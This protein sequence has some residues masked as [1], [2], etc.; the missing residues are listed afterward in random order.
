MAQQFDV[1]VVGAGIVGTSV[2]YRL[3][4]RG[5]RVALV[6]ANT[7]ASGVSSRSFAWF[8]SEQ[9]RPDTYHRLNAAGMAEWA[10]LA[11]EVPGAEIH[12]T[13]SLRWPQDAEDE[14]RLDRRRERLADL[15]HAARWVTRGEVERLEPGVRLPASVERALF[16]EDDGWVDPPQVIRALLDDAGDAITLFEGAPVEEVVHAGE[17]VSAVRAGGLTMECGALV[18]AAG[19]GTP[20]VATL[21]GNV[22]PVD[23]WPG[24]VI[25]TTPVP[26]GTLGRVVHDR[27]SDIRPDVSGGIRISAESS[28][29]DPG[30]RAAP[31]ISP[32]DLL[33]RTAE[34]LPAL[35][36]TSVARVLR[37]IRPIPGDGV[38]IAGRLPGVA[39]A[40]VAV[41]HSGVTLGPLLG[42]LIASEVAGEAPDPLLADFRPERFATTA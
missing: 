30:N 29:V 25:V 34:V 16:Y 32:D 19:T 36:A 22:V 9:K 38:T 26:E 24:L 6:E 39:N 5:L 18:V 31:A 28:T 23:P 20:E 7:A 14:E 33:L 37:G 40:W 1:A 35:V 27:H 3:A 12:R 8:N 4:G 21:L 41:T 11:R 42:R 13:G 15:G 10:A 17:V 2:A